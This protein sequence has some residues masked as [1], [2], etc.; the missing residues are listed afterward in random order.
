VGEPTV[1]D[2]QQLQEQGYCVTMD[3]TYMGNIM[4]MIGCGVWRINMMGTVQANCTS[5]N[6]DCTKLIKKGIDNSI[7]GQHVWQLLCFTLWYDNALIGTL[8]NFH[9]P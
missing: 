9:V 7:C 3:S 4:A 6:I 1:I 2:A 8:S 5:A